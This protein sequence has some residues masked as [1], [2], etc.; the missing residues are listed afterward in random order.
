MK[1][2]KISAMVLAGIMAV[3]FIRGNAAAGETR[4]YVKPGYF[5]WNEKIDGN[6]FVNEKGLITSVGVTHSHS[7]AAVFNLRETFEVWGGSVDYD[8]HDVTNTRPI[9]TDTIY[10]GTR[11]ELDAAF[12]LPMAGGLTVAPLAG[13]GHKF[14]IRTRSS[15]DWNMLYGRLGGS[16]KLDTATATFSVKA[17]VTVPFY[18]RNHVNLNASGFDDVVT[19]PKGRPAPFAEAGV[20]SGSWSISLGYEALKFDRSR[21]VRVNPITP[22]QSGVAVVDT[23]AFQ[24][25]SESHLVSVKIDYRF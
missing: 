22:Q 11:T 18:T 8:G 3:A 1:S 24:P 15:E 13:A 5:T 21:P 4:V 25:E 23:A 19:R 7:I 17:G 10:L 2:L 6:D 9:H 14:W 20:E 16:A 12:D